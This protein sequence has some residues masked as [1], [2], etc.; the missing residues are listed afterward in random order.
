MNT[1]KLQAFA[2]DAR[3]QLMNAVQA[4]LDAALVPNSDAQVDDP[5]AFAFLKREIEQAGGSEQ[6]RKH[7][8]ERYAYRWFNRIIA[9]RYMD[10]HGFTG[11]P[12]VSPAGLTSTNG[13]PEVLAAAKRGEY[14]DSTVFSLRVNGKAKERIEGLLSGSIWRMIRRAWLMVCCC[15]LNAGSGIVTCRSCSKTS[16]RRPAEWMNCSCQPICSPRVPC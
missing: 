2:T 3:R 15:N 4:R 14:D 16:A 6:G 12:V 8:V 10:V 13:L 5:R 11:T 7:V 1:S 9:F